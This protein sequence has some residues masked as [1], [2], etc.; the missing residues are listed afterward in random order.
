MNDEKRE[1]QTPNR[2]GGVSIREILRTIGKRIWYVLGG[3]LLLALAAVLI[4]MFAINPFMLNDSMS[5]QIDYPMYSQGKYPDGSVF[6]YQDII[7]KKVLVAAK[8]NPE[9][10]DEFASINVNSVVKN[11]GILISARRAYDDKEAPYIYT[12]TLNKAYFKGVNTRNFIKALFD[13]Y[14]SVII[15]NDKVSTN[16]NFQLDS[17]IFESASF[18]DQISLLSDLKN[19]LLAQY[20]SWISEYSAGR[21]VNGK[22]LSSYRAEII[23]VFADNIKTPIE[24]ILTF[25]GYEYFNKS[26][27][28]EDVKDR[29]EQLQD[30]LKLDL[31]ILQE[32][33]NYY[34]AESSPSTQANE[35]SSYVSVAANASASPFAGD[36]STTASGGDIVIMPGD[37][38]LSQK[39]AYYSE[40]AAIIQQQIMRLTDLDFADETT[41]L[42]GID[43]TVIA[44]DIKA[45][46]E[47]YL[48]G[49]LEALNKKADILKSVITSIYSSDTAVIFSSQ[50]VDSEGDTSLLIVG[51]GVFIVSFLVFVIMAYSRGKKSA[52]KQKAATSQTENTEKEAEQTDEEDGKRE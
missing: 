36:D 46:G 47:R 51:I 8:N 41:D 21:I 37:S 26:V 19:T 1:D 11:D 31:A 50:K 3:A 38:D 45:F 2:E 25:K 12:V 30:E 27:T 18:N 17:T 34:T 6:D 14:K 48:D 28:A 49:Q 52:I 22:P 39:M 20:N 16:L 29:V 35:V 44:K 23:T 13:A 33:K 4:F 10:K 7:S 24:N 43:F 9:Y 15:F 5:F 32:L 42:D 40:R